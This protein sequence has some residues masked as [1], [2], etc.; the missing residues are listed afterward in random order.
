MT[1]LNCI[2]GVT[3]GEIVRPLDCIYTHRYPDTREW[4]QVGDCLRYLRSG[5]LRAAAPVRN[6][7]TLQGGW[8]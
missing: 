5:M 1:E 6:L 7:E 8:H 2:V 4:E 3:K